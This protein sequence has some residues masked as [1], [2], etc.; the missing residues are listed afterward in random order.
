[1]AKITIDVVVS[2]FQLAYNGRVPHNQSGLLRGY[3][4]TNET[5]NRAITIAAAAAARARYRRPLFRS[6]RSLQQ[7]KRASFWEPS[8]RLQ[9]GLGPQTPRTSERI[10]YFRDHPGRRSRHSYQSLA[11][12][13]LCPALV[14]RV[15]PVSRN[16]ACGC[17]GQGV[18]RWAPL[19]AHRRI[20]SP[21]TRISLLQTCPTLGRGKS[22]TFSALGGP[23]FDGV[24]PYHRSRTHVR[25][26]I[27]VRRD[28]LLRVQDSPRRVP[29]E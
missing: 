13:A 6:A 18:R 20:Q 11:R 10:F 12:S 14:P 15:H 22:R 17:A 28:A 19:C 24:S 23:R 1:M 2:L 21:R 7:T 3:G 26:A 29:P 8:S 4:E 9:S 25:L 5:K 27:S 16:V